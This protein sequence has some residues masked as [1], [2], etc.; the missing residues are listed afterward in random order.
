MNR[1]TYHILRWLEFSDEEIVA[2]EA[3][4]TPETIERWQ[5]IEKW[6]SYVAGLL[7]LLSAY[8]VFSHGELLFTGA[9][10]F[11]NILLG[12]AIGTF[13]MGS[14]SNWNCSWRKLILSWVFGLMLTA[15]STVMYAMVMEPV[16]FSTVP[17]K[18]EV[19][20]E[21][22]T[23]KYVRETFSRDWVKLS[24]QERLDEL[25]KLVNCEAGVLKLPHKVPIEAAEIARNSQGLQADGH[26]N[27]LFKKI[28]IKSD[29][30]DKDDYSLSI[31]VV[32]HEIYHAYQHHLADSYKKGDTDWM[33]EQELQGA[34]IYVDEFEKSHKGVKTYE[35]YYNRRIEYK[36]RDYSSERCRYYFGLYLWLDELLY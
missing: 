35:E 27:S 1:I 25:Q 36:A 18:V 31:R 12:G 4:D 33:T 17:A 29:L 21:A 23:I 24:K 10:S 15:G 19:Q 30:L 28:I 2:L 6:F 16:Y 9:R 14:C 32:L 34:P 8:V 26:Y 7:M 22:T 11:T 5:K 3:D 13:L 20:D